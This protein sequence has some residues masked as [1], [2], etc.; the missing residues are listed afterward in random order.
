[1]RLIAATNRDL[2]AAMQAREFREDL[3]FRLS[4]FRLRIPALAERRQDILPL[5]RHLLQMYAPAGETWVLA[6]DAES[7]LI[8]YEWPGNV[9]ELSNVM[10]RA[11]VLSRG[12]L[13]TAEHLMF[14][15]HC[16]G[17]AR[18]VCGTAAEPRAAGDAP[19]HGVGLDAAVRSSEHRVIAA[20]LR[21]SGNRNEAAKA[22][23]I[24][25][26]TLRYKLAQ[27]RSQGFSV[28]TAKQE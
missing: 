18:A 8:E 20:A 10:Q 22:L 2:R 4:T 12:P 9:R 13:I 17:G 24:S 5:C 15:D 6:D 7:L 1:V 25:P 14:E 11:L 16:G 21:A 26:R 23:G 19:V 28:A 27:L 3:Y